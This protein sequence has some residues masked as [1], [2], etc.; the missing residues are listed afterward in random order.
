M[1]DAKGGKCNRKGR[2]QIL[3]PKQKALAAQLTV[4]PSDLKGKQFRLEA[5]KSR[6]KKTRWYIFEVNRHGVECVR[7]FN[8][9]RR[10]WMLVI[11]D[12]L[13]TYDVTKSM[14]TCRVLRGKVKKYIEAKETE[15]DRDVA[16]F[17]KDCEEGMALSEAYA[18]LNSCR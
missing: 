13:W 16:L 11:D 5:V 1:A 2:F 8:E 7:D 3:S 12:L 14:T 10:M 15:I 4:K 18:M 6:A 17:R 9:S